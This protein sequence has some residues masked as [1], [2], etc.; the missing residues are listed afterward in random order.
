VIHEQKKPKK[1]IIQK[2]ENG[3]N[4]C[5]QNNVRCC[6]ATSTAQKRTKHPKLKID[7]IK[8]M[9]KTIED[10]H[11]NKTKQNKNKKQYKN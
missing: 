5:Q 7:I 6:Y 1:Y 8:L 2:Q 3:R 11:K 4:Q 10:T 9:I